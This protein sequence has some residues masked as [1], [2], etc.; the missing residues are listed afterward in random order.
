MEKFG[1]ELSRQGGERGLLRNTLA[2]KVGQVGTVD[3][4]F[5]LGTRDIELAGRSELEAVSRELER[6][7]A[8]A[9]FVLND[10]NFAIEGAQGEVASGCLCFQ[11]KAE[12]DKRFSA[13]LRIR[14][15]RFQTATNP[16]EK[17]DFPTGAHRSGER[18]C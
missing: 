6:I 1:H 12:V 7:L 3:G 8:A 14:L 9:K 5:G 4:K 13:G 16:A 18:R 15:G 17:V 10:G 2:A 11:G